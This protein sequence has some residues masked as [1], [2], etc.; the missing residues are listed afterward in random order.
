MKKKP[1]DNKNSPGK[2]GESRMVANKSALAKEQNARHPIRSQLDFLEKV[3]D[4]SLNLIVAVDQERKIV[5]FNKAAQAAFGYKKKEVL[6]KHI[7]ML[8]SDSSEGAEIAGRIRDEG[9]FHGRVINRRKNGEEF[10]AMLSAAAIRSDQGE[11][12]GVVGNSRDITEDIRAENILQAS[13]ETAR[14]LLNSPTESII[15]IDSSGTILDLNESAIRALAAED[16]APVGQCIF[17]L[18]GEQ[19]RER[20]SELVEGCVQSLMP[21]KYESEREVRLLGDAKFRVRFNNTVYPIR[22]ESG[23]VNRL[24][25][26]S[27][28][29]A[30]S[31]RGGAGIQPVFGVESDSDTALKL[32]RATVKQ[33]PG[34]VWCVD[35]EL[36]FTLSDGLGLKKLGLKPGQVV[37]MTLSE[38]RKTDEP[39]SVEHARHKQAL[40]GKYVEYET[41]FKAIRYSCSLSPLR[42]E[43]GEIIGTLGVAFDLVER[44]AL[45]KTIQ[46]EKVTYRELVENIAETIFSLDTEGRFTYISPA[47]EKLLGYSP[48]EVIGH[49]FDR[50]VLKK[51]LLPLRKLFSEVLGGSPQTKKVK[52]PTKSKGTKWVRISSKPINNNDHITGISGTISDITTG[53]ITKEALEESEK[54]YLDLIENL[55]VGV[56]R[57]S[58]EPDGHF[59]MA[60]EATAKICGF[61]SVDELLGTPVVERY[62]DSKEY[63]RT[64]K[65]IKKQGI[66]FEE[67]QQLKKTDG[68]AV[69]CL[70]TAKAGKDKAGKTPY[71]DGVIMDITGRKSA[72]EA[73]QISEERFKSIAEG[74]DDW[75]WEIG[76]DLHVR[77]SNASVQD[78]I[79]YEPEEVIGIS[80]LDLMCAE[81]MQSHEFAGDYTLLNDKIFAGH[82]TYLRHKSGAT[83]ITESSGIPIFRRDRSFVGFQGLTK[84]IT[85]AVRAGEEE[86]NRRQQLIQAD[87]MISLGIL[88][89]GVAHEINNPNQFIMINVHIL[90]RAWETVVPILDKFY[91]EYGDFPLG[92]MPYSEMKPKIP[93]LYSGIYNGAQRI[94][95]IVKGLKDYAR[96][97]QPEVKTSISVNEVVQSSLLI[98]ANQVNKSTND[99]RV[100]LGKNIPPVSGNFQRLEQVVINLIQNACQ[101]LNDPQQAIEINSKYDTAKKRVLIVI[102]DEGVGIEQGKKKYI[103]DPFYSS[104]RASGGTGLGLSISAGIIKDHDGTMNFKSVQGKGTTATVSLPLL[105]DK[106]PE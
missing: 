49:R 2:S 29:L 45:K 53:K 87:K 84:D 61:E 80:L 96:E 89:S 85:E 17:E 18:L 35:R 16:K 48:A 9:E 54:K 64:L 12:I 103:L 105:K 36:R 100:K 67:E 69:W 42:D 37:G 78:V 92:G 83:V 41:T 7:D 33:L 27:Y 44:D 4:S 62:F 101:A 14:V 75:I 22:D 43:K 26:F 51:D 76:P 93:E 90:R 73:L 79:G 66:L 46:K 31:E 25:V 59:I 34:I 8:Y 58:A 97:G 52:L 56:F 10:T 95:N 91:E 11:I 70:V 32:F 71:Y 55:P 74:S 82:K 38:F 30:D 68:T 94:K 81:E 98:L 60:N 23:Q 63:A 28:E 65:K 88:V 13:E 15:L 50:Y 102:R 40:A 99:L 21:A 3:I 104:K 57:W 47:I 77:Y 19:E 1:S 6:G 86:E 72:E 20:L 106:N 39:D 5:E 24:A